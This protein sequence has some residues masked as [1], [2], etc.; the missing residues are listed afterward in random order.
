MVNGGIIL[1]WMFCLFIIYISIDA[2]IAMYK[3]NKILN[4]LDAKRGKSE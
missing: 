4:E 3:D 2:I 1:I